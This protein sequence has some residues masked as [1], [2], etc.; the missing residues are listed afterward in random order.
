M[1]LVEYPQI[2]LVQ[3]IFEDETNKIKQKDDMITNQLHTKPVYFSIQ[4]V[5]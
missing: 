5:Q 3:V 4:K 2:Y 1:N